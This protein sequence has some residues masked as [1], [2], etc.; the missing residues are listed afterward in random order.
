MLT[1]Q[2][3]ELLHSLTGFCCKIDMMHISGLPNGHPPS[4]S[5]TGFCDVQQSLSAQLPNEHHHHPSIG[6]HSP[7]SEDD[8]DKVKR[9]M[10]AFMVWSRKM[11]KKIADENP[12]MHNSEIS[13]RLGTQWK[14][15]T[16][17]EKRPYIDE[18]KKLREAHM[19]K[20]PNYKYKP[21]RKKPQPIRR[22]PIEMP[23]PYGPFVQ[24]PNSLPSLSN[25]GVFSRPVWTNG[26]L[27]Y[28]PTTGM[29]RTDPSYKYYGS[30]TYAH[31]PG[32]T[33]YT[34]S[35]GAGA[36]STYAPRQT[37]YDYPVAT[38]SQW[39]QST[40]LPHGSSPMNGYCI[41]GSLQDFA[42]PQPGPLAS[43]Y[44]S[45]PPPTGLS[46]YI[47]GY[48]STL[49]PSPNSFSLSPF[50]TSCGTP[51]SPPQGMCGSL[52]SPVGTNSPV[53]SV[54]SYQGPPVG[55]SNPDDS[56]IASPPST[57]ETD[58]SSMINVYL[59]DAAAETVRNV[60]LETDGEHFKLLTT[61]SDLPSTSSTFTMSSNTCLT[62]HNATVP[63]Q[64]LHS[65]Q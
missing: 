4:Y 45:P 59:D 6:S 64:H 1:K 42:E 17:D 19:K 34:P 23:H 48:S 50:S 32:S 27:S 5:S 53:G 15:L 9:P 58:L 14:A 60:G 22:F 2:Q 44:D 7:N 47:N 65:Y 3:F 33:Y 55:N 37:G 36:C 43:S 62:T 56:G 57:S 28:S 61:C 49:N 52:D 41:S 39:D 12:K 54:D 35:F 31:S 21:K 10:N 20:H 63:L 40:A 46:G 38:Q 26:Q 18:A 11:R 25:P 16:D 13:K 29:Q 24:R 8:D 30:P 51:T